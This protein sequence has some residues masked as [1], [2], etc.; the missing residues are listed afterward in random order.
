MIIS[1]NPVYSFRTGLPA[2]KRR[3][4]STTTGAWPPAFAACFCSFQL[5]MSPTANIAGWDGSC[6]VFSTLTSLVSVSTSDPKDVS[7]K[8][9]L[10]FGPE[11][12]TCRYSVGFVRKARQHGLTT[13][14]ALSFFPDRKTSS[15]EPEGG[16]SVINSPKTK[17][18][19][20]A[21]TP[22]LTRFLY[23]AGYVSFK[24]LSCAC[25]IVIFLSY[26]WV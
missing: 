9:V 17:S 24:R 25:T 11:V 26:T 13:R 7:M 21:T 15:P 10:G 5:I 23:L 18:I 12:V 20:R 3:R 19:C 2:R 22:A 8:P 1:G 16:N 14:P 6:K 4:F